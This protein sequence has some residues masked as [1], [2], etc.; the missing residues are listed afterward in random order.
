MKSIENVGNDFSSSFIPRTEFTLD[1]LV[2]VGL[3]NLFFV[4]TLLNNSVIHAEESPVGNLRRNGREF[5]VAYFWAA[6]RLPLLTRVC[7]YRFRKGMSFS[8]GRDKASCR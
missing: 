7:R 5:L 8:A 1:G 3:W 2:D 4:Q 6:C